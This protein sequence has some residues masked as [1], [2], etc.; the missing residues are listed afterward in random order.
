MRN[1]TI[2]VVIFFS[3]LTLLSLTPTSETNAQADVLTMDSPSECPSGGCAVGQRINFITSFT[4]NPTYTS[5]ANTQVCIYVSD[6]AISGYSWAQFEWISSEGI[7]SGYQYTEG[8]SNS[9]CSDQTDN[10]YIFLEGAYS[11]LPLGTINDKLEFALTI[12]SNTSN[13]G[14]VLVKIF[15]TDGGGSFQ[16]PETFNHNIDIPI[17]SKGSPAYVARTPD[18]CGAYSPCY[19]NSGDDGTGGIGTG[20]RDAINT[21]EIG[22]E[23]KILNDYFI[24]DHAVLVD[25]TLTIRGDSSAQITYAGNQYSE[26]MLTFTQGGTIKDLMINDGHW[27]SPSRTLIQVN[28]SSN[29]TIEHN[30]LTS[31]DK[32]IDIKSIK[33]AKSVTVRFNHIIDNVEAIYNTSNLGKLTIYANN[34]MDNGS[35]TQI[36]C[37]NNGSADH[38]YWGEDND[39]EE[40]APGCSVSNG[41]KLGA[42]ILV[43]SGGVGVEAVPK[44]VTDT[45]TY[46]VFDHDIGFKHTQG[47]NFDI[48]IVNHGHIDD[49]NIPFLEDAGAIDACS[50][51]YDIFLAENAAPTNLVLSLK[52]DLTYTC[53]SRIESSDYCN[54]DEDRSKYP[55]WWYD[56]A[57][58]ITNGWDRTGQDPEGSGAGDAKGQYTVCDMEENTINVTINDSGR[59]Y[60][61]D[62]NFTPFVAGLPTSDIS[63]SGFKGDYYDSSIHLQWTTTK[64]N[65]IREFRIYRADTESGNYTLIKSGI[66]AIGDAGSQSTITYSYD[67]TKVTSQRN[68]YYKLE[69]IDDIG[70]IVGI[71]GPI[72]IYTTDA[73]KTATL[74]TTTATYYLTRTATLY[75]T[76]TPIYIP[77]TSTARQ[78]TQVRTY[79]PSPN[80][81]RTDYRKPTATPTITLTMTNGTSY[82][83]PINTEG[84]PAPEDE[85]SATSILSPTPTEMDNE[86]AETN[87]IMDWVYLLIGA[88]GGLVLLII[89]SIIVFKSYIS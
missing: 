4:A 38:N 41:K 59:P 89:I 14:D 77:N 60:L 83:A 5:G 46:D 64:E 80:P 36:H 54:Q 71:Y 26:P 29:L 76:Q 6:N 67:D 78:P 62:L 73:T 58:N 44:T 13:N 30:T 23:I 43:S 7:D 68:Y 65:N 40:N 48:I 21:A 28:T 66:D 19:V 10:D 25:K 22:W 2:L 79:R 56:P 85:R 87:Q 47:G 51:F 45:M 81:T 8:E 72:H 18:D 17:T 53:R 9:I 50:N 20:L 37:N 69:V 32:A 16:L 27:E 75:P 52:Y 11:S 39:A 34:I 63:I 31:G 24:K 70:E 12:H 61:Q 33:E 84:Y 82:P 1:K 57:N 55:L 86:P 49:S 3:L 88:V 35:V 74:P 15:E 42:P